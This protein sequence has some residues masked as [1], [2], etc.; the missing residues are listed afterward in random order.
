M[1][2]NREPVGVLQNTVAKNLP[3]VD[4]WLLLYPTF[5]SSGLL[6]KVKVQLFLGVLI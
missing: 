2:N 3:L 4:I 1:E 6:L 5:A